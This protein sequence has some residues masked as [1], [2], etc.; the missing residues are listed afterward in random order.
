MTRNQ[1]AGVSD[2]NTDDDKPADNAHAG[3]WKPVD[4]AWRVTGCDTDCW[5]ALDIP[6]LISTI[7]EVREAGACPSLLVVM[8][9]KL[10]PYED[11]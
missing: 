9:G 10:L 3:G 8:Q 6:T 7:K 2:S 5:S 4:Q 11:S 1:Q